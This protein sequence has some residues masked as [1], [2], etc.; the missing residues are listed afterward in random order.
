MS[1]KRQC[2]VEMSGTYFLV[3]SFVLYITVNKNFKLMQFLSWKGI[4][5]K[6]FKQLASVYCVLHDLLF[7]TISKRTN[8]MSKQQDNA[9]LNLQL[10]KRKTSKP[11]EWLILNRITQMVFK[12]C[13]FKMVLF[14]YL[15]NP[16]CFRNDFEK[17]DYFFGAILYQMDTSRGSRFSTSGRLRVASS[18]P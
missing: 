6:S 10:Q 9:Y 2:H 5:H 13:S 17:S 12:R 4:T 3:Y 15:F 18:R 14:L 8:R 7:T 1:W 16:F 11:R